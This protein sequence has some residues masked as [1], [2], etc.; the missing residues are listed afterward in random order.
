MSSTRSMAA[1]LGRRAP[2]GW[3]RRS[4]PGCGGDAE[5]R[6]SERF[7]DA[8]FGG[9]AERRRAGRFGDARRWRLR[10]RSRRDDDDV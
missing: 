1:T 7:G 3:R 6:R 8:G 5:R 4:P 9:D 2:S 10:R